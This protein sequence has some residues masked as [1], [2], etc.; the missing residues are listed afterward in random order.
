M[1]NTN[2]IKISCYLVTTVV[3]DAYTPT[4]LYSRLSEWQIWLI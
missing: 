1:A 3:L 2:F 4:D